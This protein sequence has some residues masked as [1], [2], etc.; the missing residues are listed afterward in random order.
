MGNAFSIYEGTLRDKSKI[1]QPAARIPI[2]KLLHGW[3]IVST[4]GIMIRLTPIR[5]ALFV[6]T[7]A[8][9]QQTEVHTSA[10]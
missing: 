3:F 9:C 5:Q 6:R 10:R 2:P 1:R 8:P 4:A 7:E